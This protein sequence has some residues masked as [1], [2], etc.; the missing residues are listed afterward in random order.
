MQKH[1]RDVIA[2]RP[3]VVDRGVEHQRQPRQRDP[4]GV[5][6]LRDGPLQARQFQAVQHEP[7]PFHVGRIVEDDE[8]EA[9]RLSVDGQRQRDQQRP[10]NKVRPQE[11][12]ARL[13]GFVG[14]RLA[15]PKTARPAQSGDCSRASAG[16]AFAGETKWQSQAGTWKSRRDADARSR[17]DR[18]EFRFAAEPKRQALR[19]DITDDGSGNVGEAV[20]APRVPV[21]QPRVIEAQQGQHRGVQVVDVDPV[22]DRPVTEFVGRAVGHSAFDAAA[23]QPDAEA[24]M[25]VVAAEHGIAGARLAQLDGGRAAELAAAQA[26]GSRPTGRA[27]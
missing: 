27:A 11:R 7:I 12:L 24:P 15:R 3:V 26:P 23:G 17:C 18:D 4:V 10:E 13:R 5:V 22:F 6:E 16:A 21:G 9:A 14:R 25:I 19:N 8:I 1:V 20:I 2:V